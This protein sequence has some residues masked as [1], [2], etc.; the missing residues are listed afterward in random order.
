M[1]D[2][3]E[4]KEK[5]FLKHDNGL[6]SATEEENKRIFEYC[7]GYKNFLN[8]AK[9]EREAVKAAVA[10]AEKKGFKP[11]SRDNKYSAGDKVYFNNR[12]K[13]VA[14]AVIGK[15]DCER[16]FNITAAH[17]DSP[18]LDLKPNPVYEEIELAL[19]KTHYYG[20]IK[21]YQWPTVPLA[22]HGVFAKKD[23]TVTEVKIGEDEND[24][25]FVVNDLLPH[26]ASE[27]CKRSLS[28]GIRG[29]EL[30]VLIGSMPFKDDEGSEL[31]KLNILKILNEKYGVTEEDFLSAELE[32]VPAFK[33]CDIGFDR[34]MIG[35]YGQDDRV[36]A[37]PALTAVLE[38]E[39][40]ER[41]AL[42]ILTDKEEIGSEGNTGLNSDFLRYVIGDIC[43]CFGKD[44]TVAL[45]NSKCLSADVNAATDPTFQ[46]VMEKRNA[47]FLNY[48]VVV[49]KY[50][51]ARG[52]SDTN[53]ASAEYVAEIR[54]MLDNAKIKWQI[55]ELGKVDIGGGGT[56]AKYIADM[57]VDVVDLGVPVLS[58]HAPFETTAKFD[59]FMC[60]KAMYEFMK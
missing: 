50:T 19:F 26:L 46:D 12:G 35:S 18:R 48:G 13:T 5:L 52:K 29:E 21:K 34:S 10:L 60:Y 28:D 51:G 20:G 9:T 30:N 15:Q 44:A 55:G 33:S 16:G 14:F 58:M 17:I 6:L 56:V 2:Y 27:Q 47:S 57:G 1:S 45:R 42:A 11:F 23:G 59:V 24:P 41:T 32:M 43:H 4:L 31:V 22:L 37:Y 25:K 3:K 7:E 53:D 38:V 39:S 36:C 40:P 8:S 49:T 54:S